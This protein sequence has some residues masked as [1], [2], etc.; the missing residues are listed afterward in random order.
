MLLVHLPTVVG[1]TR[2]VATL[3]GER[4]LV[5]RVLRVWADG[6]VILED[7]PRT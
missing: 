1:V 2:L 4:D 7:V 6:K 3:Q 5:N